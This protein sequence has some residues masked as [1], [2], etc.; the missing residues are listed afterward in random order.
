MNRVLLQMLAPPAL[1]A[2]AEHNVLQLL[3]R[4]FQNQVAELETHCH[5]SG[6][7]GLS[8]GE[9]FHRVGYFEELM[10]AKGGGVQ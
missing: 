5:V 1:W 10:R 4:S 9:F 8:V 6:A 7:A 3:E 2:D